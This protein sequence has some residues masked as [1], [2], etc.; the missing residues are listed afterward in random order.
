MGH[1]GFR[2]VLCRLCIV[3]GLPRCQCRLE[4]GWGCGLPGP[5]G[6]PVISLESGRR[7]YSCGNH[8]FHTCIVVL[9]CVLV[10]NVVLVGREW[11]IVCLVPVV[12]CFLQYWA[13]SLRV[14]RTVIELWFQLGVAIEDLVC[15]LVWKL[16]LLRLYLFL[17]GL[18]V[19]LLVCLFGLLFFWAWV[20]LSRLD[21]A[22]VISVGFFSWFD[23]LVRLWSS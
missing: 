9:C 10:G 19:C 8:M 22:L 4:W 13:V 14:L 12:I 1:S 18:E 17:C 7:S 5:I 21:S 23:F 6:C 16:Y 11:L 20:I 3:H 15:Q 2:F